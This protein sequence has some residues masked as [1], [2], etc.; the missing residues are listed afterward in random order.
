M[1]IGVC[2]GPAEWPI[3]A[4]LGYDFCEANFSWLASLD[5]AGFLS[6]RRKLADTGLKAEC[7]N[8]FFDPQ[9]CLYACSDQWL[10]EYCKRTFSRARVLGGDIAVIGS[11]HSRQ[12]PDGMA[13]A[14]AENRFAEILAIAGDAASEVG[15]RVVIEPL[16]RRDC[17]FINTL[18]ESLAMCRRVNHPAVGTLLDFFHFYANGETLDELDEAGPYLWHT[19]LARPRPDRNAPGPEDILAI[20]PYA[21]ALKRIGY[22]G[23]MSLECIW[24]PDF[25]TALSKAYPVMDLFRT[26]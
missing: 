18:P 4:D 6:A 22:S 15:M 21:Q 11:G 9:V 7:F 13:L 8:G 23:R 5:D 10:M 12:I 1:R 3:L 24:Q 20:T 19:H 16:S 2:G 14:D 17:N 26:V 25:R